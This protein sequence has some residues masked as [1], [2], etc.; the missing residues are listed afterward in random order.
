MVVVVM[1][2]TNRQMSLEVFLASETLSAVRTED[3]RLRVYAVL[4][5]RLEEI[6]VA[7]GLEG[8]RGC[9]KPSCQRTDRDAY[10]T[11]VQRQR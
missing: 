5:W 6:W 9:R 4:L 10:N 1:T 3:H 2:L 8:G 11:P 7:Y